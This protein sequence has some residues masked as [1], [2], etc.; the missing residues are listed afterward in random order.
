MATKKQ[1]IKPGE[2]PYPGKVPEIEPDQIPETPITPEEEPDIIP[3]DDPFESPP[4]EI[5]APGEAP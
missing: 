4:E 3:D 2:I 5:P 1:P